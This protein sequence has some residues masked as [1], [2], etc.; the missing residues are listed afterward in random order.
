MDPVHRVWGK[1]WRRRQHAVSSA[2][3]LPGRI[4]HKCTPNSTFAPGALVSS[5]PVSGASQGFAL[6]G[7]DDSSIR[8]IG[9]RLERWMQPK[10]VDLVANYACPLPSSSIAMIYPMVNL[11]G[12]TGGSSIGQPWQLPPTS[13][14]KA[15]PQR[16][17]AEEASLLSRG[18]GSLARIIALSVARQ[19]K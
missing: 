7:W 15:S 19:K 6:K 5:F 16:E 14:S 10:A 2:R 9:S 13:L 17:E 11:L 4:D 1:R 3:R 8:G 12:S 18:M